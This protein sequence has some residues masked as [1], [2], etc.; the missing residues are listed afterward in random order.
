M[1]IALGD[2]S[3]GEEWKQ[4][5]PTPWPSKSAI[6]KGHVFELGLEVA[7]LVFLGFKL[8]ATLD[9]HEEA[10]IFVLD[11]LLLPKLELLVLPLESP[12]GN[13]LILHRFFMICSIVAWLA[14]EKVA[15]ETFVC[16]HTY[17]HIILQLWF[18]P[19]QVKSGC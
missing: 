13:T 4:A 5:R 2:L 18:V 11:A 16:T 14:L 10:H 12:I 6:V 17:E 8:Y 1:I 9:P 7:D 15:I 19:K 3:G